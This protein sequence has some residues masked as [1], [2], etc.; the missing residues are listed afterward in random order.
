MKRIQCTFRLPEDIVSLI[1]QQPG[2]TRTEKLLSLIGSEKSG[3]THIMQDAIK[4]ALQP[5]EERL[6]ALESKK[7][8]PSN[9]SAN[10]QRKNQ[11][12]SFIKSEL[13]TLTKEQIRVIHSSRYPLSEIRKSTKITKSQCDSYSDMIKNFI[14][15]NRD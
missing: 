14:E 8:T 11:T 3:N 1:D 15:I 9:N 4:I 5:I 13:D 6:T 10:Q 7:S 2:E 12:I